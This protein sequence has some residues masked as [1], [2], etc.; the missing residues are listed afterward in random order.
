MLQIDSYPDLIKKSFRLANKKL[1]FFLTTF[2]L[3]FA[4]A[5]AYSLF[6][7]A[8]FVLL[9]FW[10]SKFI[11]IELQNILYLIIFILFL[12]V[13]LKLNAALAYL[14]GAIGMDHASS[15]SLARDAWDGGFSFFIN[16]FSAGMLLFAGQ[17]LV[18]CPCF[19][20]QTNFA[21]SPYLYMYE[22]LRNKEARERSVDITK[23]FGKLILQRTAGYLLIGYFVLLLLLIT[24]LIPWKIFW[25]GPWLFIAVIVFSFYISLVQSQFIRLIY[26]EALQLHD[27]GEEELKELNNANKNK[28]PVV[29]ILL[30]LLAVILY[31]GVKFSLILLSR[32]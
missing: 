7:A 9:L 21:F 29:T 15:R 3:I 5:A 25:F 16:S 13:L 28:W 10:L 11:P 24:L 27:S 30:I 19:L 8:I 31:Y 32:R 12:Y 17:S 18:I 23:G 1:G 14:Y 20:L 22:N 26:L 2:F 4:I 6:L